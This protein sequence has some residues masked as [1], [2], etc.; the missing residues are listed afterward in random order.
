MKLLI[1]FKIFVL[2]D[3]SQGQ[4]FQETEF[5]NFVFDVVGYIRDS[6]ADDELGCDDEILEKND[7]HQDLND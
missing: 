5:S 2:C 1:D 3:V 6:N 7:E 4:F